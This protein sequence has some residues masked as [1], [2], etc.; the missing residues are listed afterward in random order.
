MPTEL[1]SRNTKQVSTKAKIIVVVCAILAI[2][3]VKSFAAGPNTF[4]YTEHYSPLE[5]RFMQHLEDIHKHRKLGAENPETRLGYFGFEH[6]RYHTP[7]YSHM[8]TMDG[9]NCC[10]GEECRP[11]ESLIDA[12]SEYKANG[13]DKMVYIDGDWYPVKMKDVQVGFNKSQL[14]EAKKSPLYQEF[15]Q[16]THVC[17]R[18]MPD[19]STLRSDK[20]NY[21]NHMVS[22]S[23]GIYCILEGGVRM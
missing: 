17:A 4:D 21:H 8:N 20:A 11:T 1:P 22:Q 23:S 15:L 14:E 5:Q 19:T 2:L 13:F 7:F 10:S 18:R 16:Q 12:P 3:M 9:H 6:N